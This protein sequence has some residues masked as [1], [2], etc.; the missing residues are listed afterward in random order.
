MAYDEKLNDRIR[1]AL[2]HLPD[3]EEKH[4][5]GGVCYMVD[6]KMCVGV[7]KDDMMC[8]VGP[9]AYEAALEKTGCRE[10]DFAARPMKGYVYV[11]EEGIRTKKELQYWIGLC[12]EYNKVA[13][14]AKKKK[15]K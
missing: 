14:A 5:F 9:D 6:G 3:V 13:K 7:I 11:G 2:A 10:M 15:R 12:L 1:E 4:M 8:R